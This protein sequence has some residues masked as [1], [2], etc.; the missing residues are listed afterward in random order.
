MKTR[1]LIWFAVVLSGMPTPA[2]AVENADK[3]IPPSPTTTQIFRSSYYGFQLGVPAGWTARET[4]FY[5]AHYNRVLLTVNSQRP[6][7]MIQNWPTGGTAQEFGAKAAFEQMQP[8]EV[9]ISIGYIGYPGPETVRSDTVGEDLRSLLATNTISASGQPGLS[10]LDLVFFKRGYRWE[11]T[12]WLRDPVSDENR[13]K[14]IAMLEGFHFVDE[15]VGNA[16]WAESLAWAK[17]PEQIRGTDSGPSPVGSFDSVGWPIVDLRAEQ[18]GSGI[19]GSH[20]VVATK[21]ASAFS[22]KF[23]LQ[24]AGIWEYLV[25]L[26]GKVQ[27]KN[28]V[29]CAVGLPVSELPSDLP[30]ESKGKITANWVAPYVLAS[31][32]NVTPTLTWFTKDGAI[33]RQM[34]V[35]GPEPGFGYVSVAGPPET[36]KAINEDWEI[37][38]PGQ[39]SE[40]GLAGYVT[41][42]PD[43]RVFFH[44]R[45]PKQGLVALDIYLHGKLANTVGPFVQ[46]PLSDFALNDDGSAGLLIWKDESKS[47]AQIVTLD[48]DA[49][50]RFRV[51]CGPAVCSLIVAPAGAGALVRPN[52]GGPDCGGRLRTGL[53]V[54]V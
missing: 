34:T 24:N 53:K 50:I 44:E 36:I 39:P 21:V 54:A 49:H 31:V 14:V 30:G 13:R 15:P 28:P 25:S 32:V 12:A 19:F 52:T 45:H 20:K 23:I 51:D 16:A 18:T 33:K 22:I 17:L 3:A 35:S 2:V 47:T 26:E 1:L 9:Y 46:Y 29:V 10:T 4:D 40:P 41:G 6:K 8:G 27:A 48:S 38:L 43:S 7:L 42:T 37:R 5:V 11:I